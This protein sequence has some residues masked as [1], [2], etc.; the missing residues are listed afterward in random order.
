MEETLDGREDVGSLGE[1]LACRYLS[2]Q[3]YVILGRN[4]R[5][6]FGEID[7]IALRDNV[8]HFV[9]VKSVSCETPSTG[10]DVSR[11]EDRVDSAKIRR[12][13]MTA[14]C[15]LGEYAIENDWVI[16]VLAV[17]IYARNKKAVVRWIGDV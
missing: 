17:E 4:Y 3:G 16:S 12:I 8:V 14:E 11:P 1:D 10:N 6:R 9:E 7:I 5:K 13:G 15:Y 2:D